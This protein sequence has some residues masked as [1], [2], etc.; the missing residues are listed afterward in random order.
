MM[1]ADLSRHGSWARTTGP[2]SISVKAL[3]SSSWRMV[4]NHRPI[5]NAP[6]ALDV[7]RRNQAFHNGNMGVA[8]WGRVD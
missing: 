2:D 4:I 8:Q 1:L 7:T 5:V 3:L 6:L